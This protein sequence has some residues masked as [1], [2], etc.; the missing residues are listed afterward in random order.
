MLPD[1]TK[2]NLWYEFDR[3]IFAPM[4]KRSDNCFRSISILEVQE[5]LE[6]S[7][8]NMF[9]NTNASPQMWPSCNMNSNFSRFQ[10]HV[11]VYAMIESVCS[12]L[13][14]FVGSTSI[15]D[16][17][18]SGSSVYSHDQFGICKA[19]YLEVLGSRKAL[20]ISVDLMLWGWQIIGAVVEEGLLSQFKVSK[21]YS[22][23]WC[24]ME[25][26]NYRSFSDC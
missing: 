19:C 2:T 15:K 22:R 18:Q 24:C 4:L 13:Q 11:I 5:C 9:V 1:T 14:Q 23:Y 7:L 8:D 16:K 3:Y 17:C 10:G 6:T 20:K 21:I 26:P 25:I 12:L